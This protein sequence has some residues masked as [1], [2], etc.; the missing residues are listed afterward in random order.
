MSHEVFFWKF[1]LKPVT[2][3]KVAI[4]IWIIDVVWI[5]DGHLQTSIIPQF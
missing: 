3:T 1:A 2:S 5:I 4:I